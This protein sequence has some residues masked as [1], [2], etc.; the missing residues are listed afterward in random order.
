MECPLEEER[1]PCLEPV[2]HEEGK[3]E[4][5]SDDE[6]RTGKPRATLPRRERP[7]IR[8][9]IRERGQHGGEDRHT[10]QDPGRVRACVPQ[11]TGADATDEDAARERGVQSVHDP[12]S[13]QRLEPCAAWALIAMSS[14]P[15]PIPMTAKERT[16]RR[17]GVREPRQPRHSTA[18]KNT[19]K[20]G[21]SR[22]P[23]TRL[24]AVPTPA[25]P[26]EPRARR[27]ATRARAARRL[28]PLRAGSRADTQPTRPSTARRPRRPRQGPSL[29]SGLQIP[30]D[31]IVLLQA[32]QPF[33][34]LAGPY[35]ADTGDRLEITLRRTDDRVQ[36]AE[37]SHHLLDDAVRQP[38]DARDRIRKP[39]EVTL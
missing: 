13:V 16:R 31:E 3:R 1:A 28:L 17:N 38:R 32:P 23:L 21:T 14:K 7:R 27:T 20:M 15:V 25:S 12:D 8:P 39:R 9:E 10:G 34:Y 24:Q 33:T 5:E 6:Q 35:G 4:H 36:V 11:Q 30:L 37:P 18:P 29:Y 26:A 19:R 2:L 22:A